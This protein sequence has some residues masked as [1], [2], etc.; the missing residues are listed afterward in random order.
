MTDS[1]FY[2]NHYAP[3]FYVSNPDSI[4][5][6]YQQLHFF[7]EPSSGW[8]QSPGLDMIFRPKQSDK[9]TLPNNSIHGEDKYDVFSL[10]NG[11][12]NIYE[13]FKL[14]SALF[15]KG[16]VINDL[17]KK[18][19]LL[20]DTEGFI[21]KFQ[22]GV[23]DNLKSKIRFST[24]VFYVKNRKETIDYYRQLGFIG[25]YD[26][27]FVAKDALYLM[28]EET[29]SKNIEVKEFSGGVSS[30]VYAGVEIGINELYHSFKSNNATFLADLKE[31]GYGKLEFVIIDPAGV[32]IKFVEYS[33]NLLEVF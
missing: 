23:G 20:R 18:E 27:G 9:F 31:N 11:I 30:D 21:I 33:G 17:G 3:I 8:V 24:K 5:A 6:Y 7:A 2:I 15:L 16:L 22:E 32:T 1:E 25:N 4:L 10:V 13:E 29:N 19:F 26:T 28:F 14:F 12:E